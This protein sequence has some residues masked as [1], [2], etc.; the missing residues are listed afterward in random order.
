MSL[1]YLTDEEEQAIKRSI[2]W[3]SVDSKARGFVQLANEVKGIA[4]VQSCAGHAHPLES[5]GFSVDSAHVAFRATQERTMQILF[6]AVPEE[7]IPDVWL[8]Y[9]DD[10]TFWIHVEVEPSERWRL[11]NLFEKLSGSDGG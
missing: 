8:R 11:F 10:G 1:H 6:D 7:G 9:F 4:T 2:P 3:D 5:G